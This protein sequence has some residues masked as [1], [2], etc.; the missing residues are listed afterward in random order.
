MLAASPRPVTINAS[1]KIRLDLYETGRD[2]P[3]VPRHAASP[4]PWME[5]YAGSPWQKGST[6]DSISQAH[7]ELIDVAERLVRDFNHVPTGSVLRCV[8]RAARQLR[9]EG[10]GADALPSAV[11]ELA[12]RR[13][14]R[15]HRAA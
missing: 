2:G 11:E 14:D 1:Q 5:S 8:A 4:W 10:V 12:R 6:V 3:K 9:A 15:R 13:L 7:R